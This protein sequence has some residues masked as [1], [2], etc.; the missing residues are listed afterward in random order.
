[1]T[2]IDTSRPET[3]LP[4]PSHTVG[5]FY[6]YALPFPGGGDIAPA[7]HPDT[8]TFQGY[9]F[10]GEG[11]PLPDAFAGVLGPRPG[12]HLSPASTARMRRDP[13]DRRLPGPQR[14]GVHRLGPRPDRRQRALDRAYAAARRARPERAVHQRVRLRARPARPSVHP[15]LPAGRRRPRSPPTRCSPGLDAARRGTLIA[16]DDGN[17]HLPFRH[18]PSGRRRDGL[19]GV[20]VTA[21]R[22][23]HRSARP[24]VGRLP[25]RGLR[26]AT[27]PTCRR[28]STPRPR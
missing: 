10:D 13:V 22:R 11:N 12:R 25:G 15:D 28:C 7:G 17:G 21:A 18:P 20:P 5:P 1:M 3:V 27:P 8:I 26:P 24:R 19:P 16:A 6:G 4:T 14:R 23:R 9:V 2:K